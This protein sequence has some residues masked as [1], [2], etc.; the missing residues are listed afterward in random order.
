MD[1]R[2]SAEYGVP[3]I[4]LM[5]RAGLAVFEAV[6]GLATPG[7]KVTVVCGSGNNGGDGH[8]VARLCLEAGYQV[9][10]IST[11]EPGNMSPECSQQM[12][13]AE[14]QGVR[15]V[16]HGDPRWARRLQCLVQSDLIVDAVLGIG[17]QGEVRGPAREAIEAMNRSGVPVLSVDVPSGIDADTG[18]ELGESVWAVATVT[19][20][21]PK[22]FL[23]QGTGLEHSGH[24]I[25]AD[26]G[27]PSDL[28]STPTSAKLICP[29]RTM[30]SIPERLRSSHKGSNGH[31]L[32]VAGSEP[33]RGAAVLCARAAFRSG[34]GMVTVASVGPVLDA[35][36][37]QVPEACLLPLETEDGAIA[38]SSA[39]RVIADQHRYSAAVFGPGLTHGDTVRETLASIWSRWETPSC[40]D[41]DALNAVACGV[42][43]PP[44]ACV[45]TPHPGEMS[46]IVGASVGDIQSDRFAAVTAAVRQTGMT[47]VLKGA[48][49][50]L[51]SPDEPL[52]VNTTGNPGMASAGMGDVLSGVTAALL[53]QGLAP[54]DAGLCAMYWHGY[55]GDICAER[56]AP[57]GF[58]ASD[59]ADALPVAR[60]KLTECAG[61]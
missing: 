7:S 8:V 27:I 32:I 11:A 35:V 40:I 22:P 24:W 20:G 36:M 55:A 59:V 2:S 56:L 34:A 31:V 21:M 28:L 41:A 19:F 3:A 17:A 42:P 53:G 47:V 38:R 6:K 5:E 15:P 61:S 43:L 18:Q 30:G 9:E 25:V 54:A 29:V 45:L 1:R 33:L 37:A 48:Y 4:V 57:I 12:L 60:A 39:E 13:Q 58:T 14:A 23:F 49:S 10:C 50:I 44:C 51:G 52:V 16:L 26:I 46:R